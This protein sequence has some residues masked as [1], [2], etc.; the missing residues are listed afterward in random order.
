M[1]GQVNSISRLS[2]CAMERSDAISG[3]SAFSECAVEFDFARE[4]LRRRGGGVRLRVVHVAAAGR[5]SSIQTQRV[6]VRQRSDS[7]A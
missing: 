6:A 1:R 2:Q 7:F 3:R 4:R 5:L